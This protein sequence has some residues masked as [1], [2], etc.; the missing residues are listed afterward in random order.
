MTWQHFLRSLVIALLGAAAL[1]LASQARAEGGSADKIVSPDQAED[2]LKA[3]AE[4]ASAPV[5]EDAAEAADAKKTA[6]AAAPKKEAVASKPVSGKPV[7]DKSAPAKPQP[8]E[9]EAAEAKEE[10]AQAEEVAA[11]EAGETDAEQTASLPAA[12]VDPKLR[13]RPSDSQRATA[14]KP[15]IARYA[16]ENGL[17]YELA[18]AIVRLESRYNPGARN[19]PHMGLTQIN[20]RTAQSLGYQGAAAGL[21]D[22]ETNLRYGL[23]YLARAYKLA[24]GDT[25]GTILRY[26]FGHRAQTMTSA[27]RTYCAKV[28]VITAAAE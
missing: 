3:A 12:P 20:F 1:T 5:E 8:A 13:L 10:G 27:S 23:K 19:G 4:E 22:A 11:G 21:L 26:Q 14:M 25:C 16:A 9:P 24:G 6:K 7:P 17:P 2:F 28:K 15:L 18:D